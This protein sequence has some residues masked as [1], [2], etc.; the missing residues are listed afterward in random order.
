[1]YLFILLRRIL[2]ITINEANVLKILIN[3]TEENMRKKLL[4][5]GVALL[6][7]LGGFYFYS[8]QFGEKKVKDLLFENIEALATS[9]EDP[10][11]NYACY[12]YGD[13][14]CH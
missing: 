9:E 8:N 12:G 6:S 1:M 5:T 10:G 4:K 2:F 3:K 13:I 11:E 14:D 7:L